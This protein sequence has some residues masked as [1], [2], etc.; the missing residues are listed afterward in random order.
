VQKHE[1]EI[2][3]TSISCFTMKIQLEEGQTRIEFENEQQPHGFISISSRNQYKNLSWSLKP[4][5]KP[6]KTWSSQ[7]YHSYLEKCH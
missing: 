7:I 6:K 3:H 1:I 4:S 2:K 5:L